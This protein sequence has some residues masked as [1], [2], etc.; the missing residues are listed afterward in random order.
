GARIAPGATFSGNFDTRTFDLGFHSVIPRA[1]Y[2][3]I[4]FDSLELMADKALDLLAF[5]VLSTKQHFGDSLWFSGTGI[6]GK[7]YQD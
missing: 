2:G 6:R 3:S 7:A 5:S 1:S 4:R